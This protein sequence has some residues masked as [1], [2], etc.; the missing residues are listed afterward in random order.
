[1]CR[2]GKI[3]TTFP[4]Y[5]F[6]PKSVAVWSAGLFDFVGIGIPFYGTVLFS[7][8]PAALTSG[9]ATGVEGML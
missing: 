6:D 4:S 3:F 1:M 5:P 2:L 9:P 8:T 7:G